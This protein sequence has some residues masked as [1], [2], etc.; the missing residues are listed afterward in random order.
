MWINGSEFLVVSGGRSMAVIEAFDL[1][2]F[3][4]A[5]EEE[6]LALRGVSLSVEAGKLLL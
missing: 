5:K 1:Y 3:Y 2:R 4:H 6:T